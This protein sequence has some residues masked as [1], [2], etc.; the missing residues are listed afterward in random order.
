M[1][2]GTTAT[3]TIKENQLKKREEILNP[4]EVLFGHQMA[5]IRLLPQW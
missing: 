4:Q 1:R 2:S 3:L 5:L